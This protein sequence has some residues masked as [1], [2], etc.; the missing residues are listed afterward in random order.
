LLEKSRLLTLLGRGSQPDGRD[1]VALLRGQVLAG[2]RERVGNRLVEPEQPGIRLHFGQLLEALRDARRGV[3][4]G[5][6]GFEL[7]FRGRGVHRRRTIGIRRKFGEFLST[8]VP[9]PVR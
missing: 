7:E 4:R 9:V 1:E 6:L 5:R 3:I 8:F 2:V